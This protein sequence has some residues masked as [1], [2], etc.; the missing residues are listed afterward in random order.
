MVQFWKKKPSLNKALAADLYAAVTCQSRQLTFFQDYRIP[1]TPFGRFEILALHLALLLRRLKFP[2][3]GDPA[4]L[5]DVTQDLC[6]FVVADVEE[7]LRA[8]RV[9]DMKI[10]HHIKSFVEGFYGR[11]VAY[12]KAL[13]L[14]DQTLLTQAIRRNVYGIVD[15]MDDHIVQGLAAYAHQTWDWLLETQLLQIIDDLKTP[16]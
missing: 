4:K 8:M 10:N 16:I 3:S 13:E 2:L 15:Q 1:D 6:N 14:G 9:S 5:Q 7:S 11:L 12:D